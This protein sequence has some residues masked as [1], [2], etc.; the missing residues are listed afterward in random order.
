MPDSGVFC[1]APWYE[2]HIYWDGSLGFCCQEAHK[3][4]PDSDAEKYNVRTMSI[5]Q[6]MNEQPMRKVRQA[7]FGD[8]PLS[9]CQRC[10][11]DENLGSTSR[12]HKCNQKSVIFT[13]TSFDKS[14]EQ[15]PGY[16][17]FHYSLE[18]QGS[19]PHMPIDL[20][21]DL[22]NYCNLSCK[23]CNPKASSQIASQY[24]KWGIQSAQRF[25]GTDWTRDQQVWQRV[26]TELA[27][28]P[29]LNNVHFMG[30]E[31]L[32]TQRFEDF[33]DYMIARGRTDLN[34]SFVTN[35][36]IFKPDLI[37]KL[38]CFQRIGIEVSIE[39]LDATNAYQR[40]GTD[41]Q[42]LMDNLR[43]YVS[44]CDGSKISLTIRPAISLLTIGSYPDLLEYCLLNKFIV[45]SMM[46]TSP[47]YLEARNLPDNI[48]QE[49]SLRFM[50]VM[51]KLDLT[52]QDTKRDYNESDPNEI[53][54]VIKNEI[55]KCLQ[56]LAQPSPVDVKHRWQTMVSWCEKWDRLYGL[57]ARHIYPEFR[58][59]LEK[60]GYDV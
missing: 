16:K 11:V 45:K 26:L 46:V 21:I 29:N 59:M 6:W 19:S 14:F 4:Y 24:V 1:S 18:N 12:R 28:I 9:I 49:Y 48:K 5:R 57:D 23:M 34:I 22:G 27:E 47:D 43:S 51:T 38:R 55:D 20:H 53:K 33:V 8:Q 42:K 7:M 37:D 13:R 32:I 25:V 60:Y 2:L 3:V 10:Y 36:T 54:S 40:Q 41:Q 30:G 44:I 58:D 31:T 35:G 17:K 39:S 56:V 50:A 15:S 52:D